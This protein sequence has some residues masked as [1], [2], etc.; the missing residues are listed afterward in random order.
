M[1]GRL[2]AEDLAIGFGLVLASAIV[3]GPVRA[4]GFVSFD[5]PGYVAENAR[6]LTGLTMENV[7][8]AFTTFY[9]ANWHPLTWLSYMADV[10]IFGPDPGAMHVVNVVFHAAN[11]LLVY[12]LMRALSGNRW[13]GAGVAA[14]FAVHPVHVESVAWISE[15][16]DVLSAFFGLLSLRAYAHYAR[17]GSRLAY[18][19]SGVGLAMGLLAKPMLVSWPFVMLLLDAWPF[20]RIGP[21]G[22]PEGRRS[23]LHLVV[24]KIPFFALSILASV[25][26]LIAQGSSD[27]IAGV[28]HV[29]LVSRIANAGLAYVA[30]LRMIVWPLDLAPLYP[31]P[32]DSVSLVRGAV[33]VAG[34]ALATLLVLR[35]PRRFPAATVGWLWF[36]GMLVPVIGLVQVGDQA[37][38]DRYTYLPALGIYLLVVVFARRALEAFPRWS[39]WAL[40]G[41]GSVL[42]ALAVAASAQRAYWKDSLTLFDHTL[43]VTR[44]NTVAHTHY[45]NALLAAGRPAEAAAQY[46]AADAIHPGLAWN[47]VGLGN[48]LLQ[49]QRVS[50]A[51][52]AFEFALAVNPDLFDAYIGMGNVRL[53][54]RNPRAALES[55]WR[56]IE[57]AP[58]SAEA[59]N[60]AGA[61][62]GALGDLAGA[63]GY[64]E[65]ALA[66]RPEYPDAATNLARARQL[67]SERPSG[68]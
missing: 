22:T 10:S 20:G 11:A 50:E 4:Y 5:D 36:L 32:G 18:A 29:A 23:S 12:S 57:L 42:V 28:E 67:L 21:L 39:R 38:A 37:Y 8:W 51:R 43:R 30:Y 45:G 53:A 61:A 14:L 46:Q 58:D 52:Q 35:H 60:N 59:Q 55:F 41:F 65:A 62:L 27:A 68:R 16:K 40:A 66:R 17:S 26:T 6:V 19:L 7:E 56:A 44:D 13:V 2:R 48:A 25:L 34:V 33:A 49:M 63:I 24:E 1:R 9:F 64:F 54:E 47:Y 3:Y 31:H 15:R